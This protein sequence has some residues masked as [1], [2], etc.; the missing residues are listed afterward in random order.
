MSEFDVEAVSR[1]ATWLQIGA[2]NMQNF[3]LL[4]RVGDIGRT[5]LLKRGPSATLDEWMASGEYLL[6][7]GAERVIFCDVAYGYRDQRET[8]WIWRL[9]F[10]LR[11]RWATGHR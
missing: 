9:L 3:S 5:V 1:S 8:R 10:T 7:S 11:P 4:K 2:R 6:A